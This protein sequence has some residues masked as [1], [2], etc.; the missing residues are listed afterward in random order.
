LANHS[1]RSIKPKPKLELAP[2]PQPQLKPASKATSRILKLESPVPSCK[3]ESTDESLASPTP[4]IKSSYATT[5]SSTTKKNLITKR[6]F[7]DLTND[8]S[9]DEDETPSKKPRMK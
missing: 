2:A 9:S 4:A 8:I 7:I 1:I 5:K 3:N 6:T